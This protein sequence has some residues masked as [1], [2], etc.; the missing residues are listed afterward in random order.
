MNE[1]K[2]GMMT[3]IKLI[4]NSNYQDERI[5]LCKCDCGTQKEVKFKLLRNQKKP[6]SCGCSRKING[7]KVFENNF[8]K[9]E[10]CWEWKGTLHK[11]GYGKFR[12]LGAHRAAYEYYID[13]IPKGILVCHICDNRKCVNPSHLF[14]GTHKDNSQDMARKLRGRH[15]TKTNLSKLNESQVLEIRKMR[16]SGKEY[17]EISDHFG[18]CWGTVGTVCKNRQ[19]KHVPLGEECSK[20]KRKY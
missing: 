19:W 18:I 15:G 16:I 13:K 14:L 3:I 5:Y 9:T 10:G 17:K 2:F 6:R 1:K 8:D 12:S 20:I 4:K 7:F 11:G